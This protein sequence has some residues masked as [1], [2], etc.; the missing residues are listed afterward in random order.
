MRPSTRR[1]SPRIRLALAGLLAL[2]LIGRVEPASAQPPAPKAAPK[3]SAAEALARLA[4]AR[5]AE[6]AKDWVTALSE[7]QAANAA[8]KSADAQAGI[9]RSYDALKRPAAAYQA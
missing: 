7:Y 2:P 9:A 3:S 4:A 1:R 8:S 5:K 6:A